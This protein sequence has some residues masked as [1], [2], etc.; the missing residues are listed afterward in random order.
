MLPA[1]DAFTPSRTEIQRLATPTLLLAGVDAAPVDQLSIARL[2]ADLPNSRT[3]TVAFHDRLNDP[4]AADAGIAL[5]AL[6][7][8][9]VESQ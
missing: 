2:A 4:F 5:A 8:G 3:A 9:I 1:L 7:E 6:L